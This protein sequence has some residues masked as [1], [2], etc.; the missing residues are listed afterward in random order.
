[1]NQDPVQRLTILLREA[2]AV[3]RLRAESIAPSSIYDP[4]Y[5]VVVIALAISVC[6][7]PKPDG[8]RSLSGPLLKLYQFV[9][10][11]A[12]LLPSLRGWSLAH[13]KGGH[14]S[15]EGWARF[16]RGYAADGLHENVVTYLVAIGELRREGKNLLAPSDANPK[17][18]LLA[19]LTASAEKGGAF[20]VERDALRELSAIKITLKMLDA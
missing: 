4:L 12:E 19:R 11:H 13:E 18:G 5:R 7:K 9:A 14:P 20:S 1:M 2:N 10:I 15:L 6:G 8:S 3:P 16:P 17:P